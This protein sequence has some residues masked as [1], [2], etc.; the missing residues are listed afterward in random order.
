MS[1]RPIREACLASLGAAQRKAAADGYF[2]ATSAS[3]VGLLLQRF[4]GHAAMALDEARR[5]VAEG[6]V[7]ATGC[8]AMLEDI[9]CEDTA[10]RH[11]KAVSP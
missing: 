2:V 1:A 9:A 3:Y 7:W 4:D 8:V 11:L 6:F 5:E 10:A